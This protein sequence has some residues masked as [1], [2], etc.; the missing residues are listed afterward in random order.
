MRQGE[1]GLR[2]KVSILSTGEYEETAMNLEM[3]N[4]EMPDRF[5]GDY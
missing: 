2:Y 1:I 4:M 3:Q 5:W